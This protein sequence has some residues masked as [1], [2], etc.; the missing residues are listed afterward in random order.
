M[1]IRLAIVTPFRS[2][3]EFKKCHFFIVNSFLTLIVLSLLVWKRRQ[4]KNVPKNRNVSTVI[5]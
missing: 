5:L 2:L 1:A 4:K 3:Q